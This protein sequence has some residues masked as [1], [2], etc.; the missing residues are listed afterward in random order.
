MEVWRNLS[1]LR[2]V[3][4]EVVGREGQGRGGEGVSGQVEEP[5]VGG[6]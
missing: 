6:D 4:H 5:A 2:G 3:V 1:V